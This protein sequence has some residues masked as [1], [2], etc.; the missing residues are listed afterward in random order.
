MSDEPKRLLPQVDEEIVEDDDELPDEC[1]MGGEHELEEIRSAIQ[2][3]PM[4][5]FCAKC[6]QEFTPT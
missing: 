1:P 3:A 4:L 6:R 5:V 2:R